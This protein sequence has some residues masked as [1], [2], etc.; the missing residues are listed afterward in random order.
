M[1]ILIIRFSSIGDIVLTSPVIRCVKEQLKN[2]ELHFLTKAKFQGLLA[3][4]PHISKIHCLNNSLKEVLA[5]LEE[6]QFDLVIDLHKSLR[7]RAIVRK[8]KLQTYS[9]K[10]LNIKKWLFTK[11]KL[12]KLPNIHLVDRY[13]EGLKRLKIKYDSKGLDY[14]I[15]STCNLPP[16]LQE[17]CKQPYTVWSL[18]GTYTT[19]KLPPGKMIE[20]SNKLKARIILIGGK[21]DTAIAKDLM[22]KS[23]SQN[24]YNYSGDLSIDQSAL[25]IKNAQHIITHDTGMM[26]IAAAFKKSI[27]VIWGNTHPSLGMYPFGYENGSTVFNHE[28]DL[29]CRPCS[30]LGYNECPKGHFNCMNL[31]NVDEIVKNCHSI[32]ATQ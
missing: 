3:A 15:P 32:D 17:V 20:L 25:L 5:E 21:E 6:E 7:S 29:K 30:K 23:S 24:L 4:N 2:A 11:F 13:F 12:N 14:F 16:D 1:K 9:F 22:N 28:V 10:K 8:L 27:S 18:G 19:K 31:Q 26:H